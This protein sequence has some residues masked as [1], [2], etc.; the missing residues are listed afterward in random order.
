MVSELKAE[1]AQL[2]ESLATAQREYKERL[3]STTQVSATIVNLKDELIA[4]S[5]ER[6]RLEKL[7]NDTINLCPHKLR[8]T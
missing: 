7:L 3:E 2:K 5:A 8:R 6:D 4:V 1:N